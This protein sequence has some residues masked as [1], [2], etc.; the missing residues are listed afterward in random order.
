[1]TAAVVGLGIAAAIALRGL[2]EVVERRFTEWPNVT[3][4]EDE[5]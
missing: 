3:A 2:L 4:G 1:M 5:C